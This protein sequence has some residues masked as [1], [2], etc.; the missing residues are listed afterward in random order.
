MK[1]MLANY[2]TMLAIS[3]LAILTIGVEAGSRAWESTVKYQRTAELEALQLRDLSAQ[4]TANGTTKIR[5][6]TPPSIGH[7]NIEK[8]WFGIK[9]DGVQLRLWPK[10]NIKVCFEVMTW[11]DGRTTEAILKVPLDNAR[12]LWRDRGLDDR[13][14]WFAFEFVTDAAW[15]ATRA[16][17]PDFLLVM[18]AGPNVNTMATTPGMGPNLPATAGTTISYEQGGPRMTLSDSTVM[19]HKNVV[20][21]YAHE[22]GVS[23]HGRVL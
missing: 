12:G 14:G 7:N 11:P 20:A 8:R 4:I 10:G 23:T 5:R 22:M 21:N 15:C 2:T 17:R 1:A 3:F 19:G 16:N 9:E 6:S 18:Y 13:D